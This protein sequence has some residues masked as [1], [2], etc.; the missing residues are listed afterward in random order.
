MGLTP[1]DLAREF[2]PHREVEGEMGAVMLD[3]TFSER[4]ALS[5][6][7]RMLLVDTQHADGGNNDNGSLVSND[8]S[9]SDESW[10][11]ESEPARLATDTNGA[12]VPSHQTKPAAQDTRSHGSDERN[13]EIMVLSESPPPPAD[14][15]ATLSRATAALGR[16]EVELEYARKERDVSRFPCIVLRVLDLPTTSLSGSCQ[17]AFP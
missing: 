13:E 7:G 9:S 3:K 11:D 5:K 15:L 2:G 16:V 1:L 6:G 8:I 4:F 17:L 12:H 10:R 14:V